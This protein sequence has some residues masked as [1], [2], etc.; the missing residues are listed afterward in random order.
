MSEIRTMLMDPQSFNG[1]RAVWTIPRGL[2]ISAGKIRVCNVQISNSNGNQIYFNHSGVYSLLSKVSVLSLAGAEIDRLSNMEIMAIKLAH[3]ENASQYSV[4]RQ[5]S[6]NMCNSIYVNNLG[7]ADLTEQSQRDDGSM[8]PIYWDISFMLS[9]LQRRTVIDE[10]MTVLLEFASPEVLGF[11]YSFIIPPVLCVD[12]F[13][14]QVPSDPMD[15]LTYTTIIQDKLVIPQGSSGFEK[16]LNSF[17]NQFLGNVYYLNVDNRFDNPL[18]NAIAPKGEVLE[19]TIDGRKIIPL[20]GIN[21]AGKKLGFLQDFSSGIVSVP[22]YDSTLELLSN[23]KGFHNPNNNLDY[24]NKFSYGAF[25][26]NRYINNDF[27]ISYNFL[28]NVESARGATLLIL[29]EVLRSYD[30]VNDK[31]SFVS[32]QSVPM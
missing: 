10:G 2:K 30:R 22:G 9:Y 23:W 17:F 20:V 16:R 28:N 6:Q 5:L 4:N 14:T 8:M 3:M 7:Q 12:E 26:L 11:Q 18:V 29:A 25:L 24:G 1:S 13:L 21:S 32:T 15:V 27:T 31:V 19:I